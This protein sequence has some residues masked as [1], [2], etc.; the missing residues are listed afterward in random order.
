MQF[1]EAPGCLGAARRGSVE[2]LGA[3]RGAAPGKKI[4]GAGYLARRRIV[5][6]RR[7]APGSGAKFPGAEPGPG[8][9]FGAEP[10]SGAVF[11][12]AEPGFGAKFGA[13]PGSGAKFGAERI[14]GRI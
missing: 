5:S 7:V 14:R 1:D 6:A 2:N 3:G 10:G 11:P 13:E 12:G 4:Q 9:K 8:L